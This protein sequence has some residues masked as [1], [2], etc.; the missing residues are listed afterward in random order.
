MN[1]QHYMNP[2]SAL[3]LVAAVLSSTTPPATAQSGSTVTI[4]FSRTLQDWDGF[5]VNYVQT[6]HTRDPDVFDQD[7]GGMKYLND[8]ERQEMI[9]LIFGDDGL[10]PSIVKCF[11]DPFHEPFNDNEDPYVIAEAGFDHKR[12]TGYMGYFLR[13]G[14]KRT[15]ARNDNLVVLAGLYGP[16]GWMTQQRGFRGRDLDKTMI[17]EVAE[18][19][20]AWA[21]HLKDEFGADVRYISMHN[22]GESYNRWPA[23]GVDD[24]T[25][26]GHD[27][28]AFWTDEDVVNFIV[29]ARSILDHHGLHGI[30]ITT[31][32]P[33]IWTRLHEYSPQEGIHLAY[34]RK[35]R[36]H[37]G[38]L[39]ALGLITSHG[40]DYG[41]NQFDDRA[42]RLLRAE[43]PDLHAWTTSCTWGTMSVDI[44]AQARGYIYR[45]G[46]N[47][48]I[49]WATVHNRL[50]SDKLHPPAG[51]RISGNANSPILTN[52]GVLEATKAYYFFKQL[53]R[54]GRSGMKVAHAETGAAA[55]IGAIAWASNGTIHPDAFVLYNSDF[56]P[57]EVRIDVRGNPGSVYEAHI[58]Q[59]H[60]DANYSP[61]RQ[62][63]RQAGAISLVLPERAAVTFFLK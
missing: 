49:P 22:E 38:A 59:D 36:D 2:L 4:D 37:P 50:E 29:A 1:H 19:L 52:H 45:A 8:L 26:Y 15:K 16:P 63:T 3:F 27:F 20:V 40:F 33:S 31:G 39:S 7:Y 14:L 34:G 51:F 48:V 46:N 61:F 13:E 56:R 25:H 57:I 6:R 30:G 11:L 5:G 10:Q 28:N 47:A 55:K 18:Y 21:K 60:G 43:R 53:T 23:D 58:T 24:P 32:E 12:T 35:I 9:N 42:I 17:P 54:A 44:V 62:G 41:G